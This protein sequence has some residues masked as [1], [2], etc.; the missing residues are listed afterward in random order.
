[1]LRLLSTDRLTFMSIFFF[2]P[3]GR[4]SQHAGVDPVAD[5]GLECGWRRP[6]WIEG[7]D[8]HDVGQSQRSKVVGR[9]ARVHILRCSL[10]Q[11]MTRVD[12]AFF[13]A[14]NGKGNGHSAVFNGHGHGN[15]NGAVFPCCTDML[16]APQST[17][18]LVFIQHLEKSRHISLSE[19][20]NKAQQTAFC[21]LA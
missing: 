10:R 12:E 9:A 4:S 7:Y 14:S 21:R 13:G 19:S 5:K 11:A 20:L 18:S 16:A 2:P 8:G 17:N 6:L 3:P 1:M 15:G